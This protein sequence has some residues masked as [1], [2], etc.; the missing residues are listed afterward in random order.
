[1]EKIFNWFDQNY[2]EEKETISKII[3]SACIKHAC[4][5]QSLF[6]ACQMIK[7]NNPNKTSLRREVKYFAKLADYGR[8]GYD[9]GKKLRIFFNINHI[10]HEKSKQT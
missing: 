3:K 4:S 2:I 5:I 1:M 6:E 9:A 10:L 7:Q 8:S